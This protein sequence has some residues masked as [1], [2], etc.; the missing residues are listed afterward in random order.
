MPIQ[1]AHTSKKTISRLIRNEFDKSCF[2]EDSKKLIETAQDYGLTELAEEMI[3]DS[4]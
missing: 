2:W 4:F 1:I 3:R